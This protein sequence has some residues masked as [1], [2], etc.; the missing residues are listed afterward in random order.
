ML[1]HHWSRKD[2]HPIKQAI[3]LS[4]CARQ[5]T[6]T[7]ESDLVYLKKLEL[8]S[9]L[10]YSPPRVY[11][12]D[13]LPRTDQ[14]SDNN[15]MTRELTPFENRAMRELVEGETIVS[16][17]TSSGGIRMV[18]ALRSIGSCNN[19]H[20]SKHHDLL[21]AFTYEF[22]KVQAK[23]DLRILTVSAG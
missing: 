13:H 6:D 9:V 5:K 7:Q 16:E 14:L 10:K 22:E 3:S 20:Q 21:G 4:S 2:R 18:G 11:L 23:P 8:I 1:A 12:L 19:C 15:A 17:E